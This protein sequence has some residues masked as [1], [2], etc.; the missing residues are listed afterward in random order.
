MLDPANTMF[1]RLETLI[2]ESTYGGKADILGS[3]RSRVRMIHRVNE[4][5]RR[6][7]DSCSCVR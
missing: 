4:A 5:V 1:P 2:I 3:K 6:G 7:G